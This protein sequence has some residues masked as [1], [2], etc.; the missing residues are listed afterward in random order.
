MTIQEAYSMCTR[1]INDGTSETTTTS[2]VNSRPA[3]D[4]KTEV[5]PQVHNS[6]SQTPSIALSIQEEFP[7]PPRPPTPPVAAG[8]P[9]APSTTIHA[10]IVTPPS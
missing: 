8:N 4:A 5:R 1:K 3:I 2:S 6:E 7:L 9:P 10:Q